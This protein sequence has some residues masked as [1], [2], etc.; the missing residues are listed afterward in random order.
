RKDE[1]AVLLAREGKI[2]TPGDMSI[3]FNLRDGRIHMAR[4]DSATVLSFG[5]YVLSFPFTLGDKPLRSF[6]E[7][8][9]LELHRAA[10]GTQGEEER[11]RITLELHRRLSLPALCLVLMV[12]GPPL[13]L[14]AG[15]SGKMGGLAMGILVFALYYG[16]VVYTEGQAMAGKIPI[17]L[18]AWG[19][20]LVLGVISLLL[21]RRVSSR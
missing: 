12:L 20:A 1:P 10:A 16:G 11:K 6:Q 18:G 21:F 3:T 15:R 14:M 5:Q 17:W 8:T 7:L 4:D 9:P 2:E 19:P 13:S